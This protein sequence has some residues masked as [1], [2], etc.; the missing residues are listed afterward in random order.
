MDAV[1]DGRAVDTVSSAR[2]DYGMSDGDSS[3]HEVSPA[4]QVRQA[5]VGCQSVRVLKEIQLLNLLRP[6]QHTE[7]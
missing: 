1:P 6:G 3:D 2:Y 4:Q 5:Y 7:A